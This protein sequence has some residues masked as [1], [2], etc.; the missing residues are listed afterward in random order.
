M[1][2]TVKYMMLTTWE[3]MWNVSILNQ[4]KKESH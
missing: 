2:N 4:E 3:A 1:S